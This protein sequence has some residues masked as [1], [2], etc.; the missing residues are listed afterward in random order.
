MG[1]RSGNFLKREGTNPQNPRSPPSPPVEGGQKVR[2][3]I[4][5]PIE[6]PSQKESAPPTRIPSR[7]GGAPSERG[8]LRGPLSAGAGDITLRR[9]YLKIGSPT[10]LGWG[11]LAS[12]ALRS[13]LLVLHPPLSTRIRRQGREGVDP[14]SPVA[15]FGY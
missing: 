7:S 10:P 15:G 13:R 4:G 14:P 6:S 3:L 11:H 2:L 9:A 1:F 12:A 8:I 5:H